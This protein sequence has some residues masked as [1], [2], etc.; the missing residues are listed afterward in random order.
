MF[1]GIPFNDTTNWRFQIAELGESILGDRLLGFQAANEP[2]L[3]GAHGHRNLTYSP[4]DFFGEYAVFTQAWQNDGNVPTK[5]NIIAPSTSYAEWSPEQVWDTG[6]VDAYGQYLSH[7]AVEHYPTD[8]CAVVFPNPENPPHDPLQM[9]PQYLTHNAGIEFAKPYLNSTALA[10]QWGKPF[11]LFE[12]NTASCGGFP[13]IS[14]S[15]TSALWGI[16]HAL[17]LANSNFTG[18]LFHF[19]GQNVS[20]N[21]FTA[22]PT[23]E[24]ALH[25]WTTGPLFYSAVFVAEVMGKSNTTRVKDMSDGEYQ[26]ESL[27]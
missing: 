6:F 25:G 3:Y 19:G 2:D 4:F 14:D 11:L 10:Q 7:L 9:L 21:P 8:N 23:N 12:T 1:P 24:S 5:N 26:T 20:Y 13:G 15:F 27:R 22:A 18:A 16:D 17:Q